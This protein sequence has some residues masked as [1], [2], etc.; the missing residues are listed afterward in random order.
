M[1]KHLIWLLAALL[2]SCHGCKDKNQYAGLPEEL[3]EL[4]INIDKHPKRAENYYKRANYYYQHEEIDKGIADMQTAIKLQ[5]DSSKYY[6]MISDLYFAQHETDLTEEMLLKAIS[7]DENNNE[8][9]LKL[10]ELQFHTRQFE[11]CEKTIDEATQRQPH[12]PKAYLI[13]AFMLKDMQ[14]T[15]GY[16]RML[17]L[18]IDQDPRETKAYLELGYFYQQRNDPMAV[19]YYQNALKVDPGNVEIHY[20]LGKMFQ[21]MDKF[22]EA[23]QEYKTAIAIDSTHIPSLNNLGYLYL[24][25]NFKKYD[26]AVELFTRVLQVNPKFVYAVCNRGVAYEYMGN[27]VA[28]R[29]DY[30]EALELSTNFEPAILG[31]NRLDKLQH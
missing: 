10:A 19:S 11:D 14:D 7:T 13:K 27:Y 31:L 4:C 21:D 29:K 16:L 3:A 8:A 18:V 20:N 5:P 23:E 2:F 1:R 9:R 30:E 25:E 12:N 24:D 22:E 26:K 6:V 28:A 15:V 17:Q